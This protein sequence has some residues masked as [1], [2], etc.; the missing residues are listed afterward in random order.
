[1]V[2]AGYTTINT[3]TQYSE[4]HRWF[5]NFN[6][7]NTS[8]ASENGTINSVVLSVKP[9]HNSTTL[10]ASE[11]VLTFYS[12]SDPKNVGINDYKK[13]NNTIIANNISVGAWGWEPTAFQNFTLN[14]TGVSSVNTTGYLNVMLRLSQDVDNAPTGFT[15]PGTAYTT[16]S[17]GLYASDWGTTSGPFLTVNYTPHIYNITNIT[18]ISYARSINFTYTIGENVDH[19]MVYRDNTFLYNLTR[20]YDLWHNLTPST[21]Y[22]ISIR[23]IDAAGAELP[24]A[25]STANT[26]GLIDWPRVA[27]RFDDGLENDY[28]VV[29]PIFKQYNL[30]ADIAVV[31]FSASPGQA[32]I[33]ATQAH[34]LNDAGWDMIVH[35]T[36]HY[37][38]PLYNEST[39]EQYIREGQE[40]LASYNLT[41]AMYHMC[42]PYG[43]YTSETMQAARAAGMKTAAATNYG[44][45]LLPTN[46][47][48]L[49]QYKLTVVVGNNTIKTLTL[50]TTYNITTIGSILSSGGP[51][52]TILFQQHNISAGSVEESE[53][54]E[55]AQYIYDR[56]YQSI[57]ISDWYALEQT[58]FP[59]SSFATNTTSG[60]AP[61]SV[62]F[63]DTSTN[64]PTSWYWVFGDGNTSTI[65]NA[66]HT[67]NAGNW[68]VNLTAT[69]AAG[70]NTSAL[71]Y[72]NVTTSAA[73]VAAF[74]SNVSSGVFNLPVQFNDT[75]T[76]SPTS[77]SWNFGDGGTSSIQNVTHTYTT[78]GNFTVTLNATNSGGYSI[79][80][81]Y[82][83]VYNQTTSDFTANTT[84]GVIPLAVQFTDNSANATSWNWTFG[85]G[86]VST[87]QSPIYIYS[88]AGVY[89]VNH[90]ATNAYWT[91]WTNKTDY[92]TATPPVI[93]PVASFTSNV[94]S[95]HPP[96][97]V[98]FNDTSSNVPTSWLWTFPDDSS[99]STDQNPIHTFTTVGNWSISLKATNIAGNNTTSQYVNVTAVSGFTRQDLTMDP[100]YT[101]TL[102][103]VDSSTNNPIPIVNV[104]DPSDNTSVNTA[105]GTY[106]GTFG[107]TTAVL[108]CYSDGYQA[109][110]VSY[111]M[112]GDRTETVQLVASTATQSMNSNVI[113]SP[114][115][116]RLKIVDAFG[117]PLPD[118]SIVVNYIASSL[119]STDTSWLV[120][121]F[122]IDSTTA[123]E[124]TNGSIAMSGIT[125]SDGSLTFTMFPALTYGLTIT[126]T[127]IGL[128]NYQTLSPKDTDYTI[129]CPLSSQHAVNNT[130]TQVTE[131]KNLFYKLNATAYNLSM[132]YQDT[133]GYTTGLVFWVKDYTHGNVLVYSHDLGNPGTSLITD[134][135][136]VIVP[137]GQEYIWGYTKTTV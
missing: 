80:T 12:P 29:Y 123:S 20:S 109:K 73:P 16:T 3:A 83:N 104:V 105:T 117:V 58:Y 49:Y 56:G 92:I 50:N 133:S 78:G 95:G 134:N 4:L 121:L 118:S 98:Q 85:D 9:Y 77:W 135:Y 36:G 66:T 17:F 68:S 18:N 7:S 102:N 37:N 89:S 122:G 70:S 69:N 124:M 63:N 91:N 10:G 59:A 75:S 61:M 100:E 71:T 114:Q 14:P 51:N 120:S 28:V 136:T 86:N 5:M 15:I 81:N 137:L 26:T 76:G 41:R 47:T 132:K 111:I 82:I 87:L 52:E 35:T 130:L 128:N 53:Y 96:L 125:T 44:H 22:T 64:T 21:Q 97:P 65:Q 1:Q 60:T 43:N 45:L 106:V 115:T 40:Y 48:E 116:V 33:T 107:Y 103:F 74:T 19:S 27:F 93:T 2:N 55:M 99:T 23:P 30:T 8:I 11:V 101:L 129:Y 32:Y 119:P 24:W 126:N 31:T 42:Y 67:F 94:S 62:Q 72:I 88:S 131:S 34:E 54:A 113:Y 39:Q 6:L 108:Y 84:S 110:A 57:S 38:L 13:Y 112:T 127:T 25:N 46:N 79:A 90:S